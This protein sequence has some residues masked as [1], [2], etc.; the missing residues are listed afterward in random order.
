VHQGTLRVMSHDEGI[1]RIV[2]QRGFDGDYLKTNAEFAVDPDE[3]DERFGRGRAEDAKP[4]AGEPAR[5]AQDVM[6]NSGY[7]ER[8][9]PLIGLNGR[10][11]GLLALH[12]RRP[13]AFSDRDEHD[14]IMLARQA[15][16]LVETYLSDQ[17][18]EGLL[19]DLRV[20]AEIHG[21]ELLE[22]EIRF[23]RAFE[24]GLVAACITTVEEDRFLEVNS[25]YV[26]LT[27]YAPGDVVGRTSRELGMWSSG[28]DQ[29]A[30][31]AAFQ[32]GGEFRELKLR[33][34]GR[35]G[36]VRDILLS[37]QR[38]TY[39]GRSCWLKMFNDVT[40]QHRSQEELMAAIRDVMSDTT[41]FGQ[42]VVQ[43]L[44][45]LRGGASED[46]VEFDLTA[47]E[48]QVLELVAAGLDD[49]E[50]AV[51][52]GIAQ[53]TVRNHLTNTYAK[54]GVH[55]RSEAVVWARDRGMVARV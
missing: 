39:D 32:A 29:A 9:L 27:G 54:T 3:L 42:S 2:A 28:R 49:E 36:H 22:S 23:R 13:W 33:L 21:T 8:W 19:D 24:V 38:I 45:E 7:R 17:R 37:G 31:E 43:K 50:I 16:S 40:E 35:E 30:L 46:E 25:G 53:K 4:T 48:R 10:V 55:S 51:R 34:R 6:E 11:V 14:L 47:R 5:F 52:I 26:K 18:S 1:L 12:W 20:R 44:A 15:A 41:W